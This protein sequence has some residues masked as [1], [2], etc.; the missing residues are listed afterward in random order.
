M[1]KG[2]KS[3]GTDSQ[4][5]H[6]PCRA[7]PEDR[8]V[9]GHLHHVQDFPACLRIFV[10]QVNDTVQRLRIARAEKAAVD[11]GNVPAGRLEIDATLVTLENGRPGTLVGEQLG[12]G[13][14]WLVAGLQKHFHSRFEFGDHTRTAAVKCVQCH[15]SHRGAAV[16]VQSVALQQDVPLDSE[17]QFRLSCQ[18]AYSIIKIIYKESHSIYTHK[19]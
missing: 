16:D 17:A 11:Q 2:H 12:T 4:A 14:R 1:V 19:S 7:C 9:Q 5:T 3:V 18:P 6:V 8:I 13:A 10:H 15:D